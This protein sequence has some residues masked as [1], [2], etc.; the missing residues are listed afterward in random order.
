M[1]LRD[2]EKSE[3]SAKLLRLLRRHPLDPAAKQ[4]SSPDRYGFSSWIA[5]MLSIKGAPKSFCNWVHGWIWWEPDNIEDFGFQSDPPNISKIV[6]KANFGSLLSNL[7]V[8][9][10]VAAGLPYA[11]IHKYSLE[12]EK[13]Q[14]MI[15]G[16]ALF[17][18]DHSSEANRV[19]H[20]ILEYLDYIDSLSHHFRH[21]SILVYSIDY[22]LLAP[23]IQ[24]RGYLP[25]IGADPRCPNSMQ[26]VKAIFDA[27]EY[28]S[29]N[30]IGSHVLYSLASECKVSI[31]GPYQDR[32][33]EVHA[34]D[35]RAGRY[36]RDYVER[37]LYYCS[38]KFL[39]SNW[40][41]RFLVED[42]LCAEKYSDQLASIVERE[43][44][45]GEIMPLKC[46]PNLLGWSLKQQIVGYSFGAGRRAR[47][48]LFKQG[49]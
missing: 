31:C 44:G 36:S 25:L 37:M 40:L 41:K 1:S 19:S 35:V 45:I 12:Q 5:K 20:N 38:R 34:D 47:Q 8:C 11:Y 7:G 24:E 10:V 14:C 33:F 22:S 49:N 46:L 30:F 4:R 2:K 18:P 21:V 6:N 16:T 39:E 17:I 28:V 15:P 27:H 13:G 9:N 42:P 3:V 23:V 48:L 43:L 26:R 29:T 32:L